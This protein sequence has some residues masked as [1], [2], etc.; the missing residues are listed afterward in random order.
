MYFSHMKPNLKKIF[1]IF[2]TIFSLSSCATTSVNTKVTSFYDNQILD[3]T[4]SFTIIPYE[5]QYN[6]IEYKTYGNMIVSKLEQFGLISVN[7]RFEANFGVM[8]RYDIG[9]GEMKTDW[10]PIINEYTN[11]DNP[12]IKD[13]ITE[14]YTPRQYV[15]YTKT[16]VVDI[17][18]LK[19]SERGGRSQI[20][21]GTV[22]QT[23]IQ[24][25][26]SSV[27]KCLIN[28]LF[29]KFPGQNGV[30]REVLANC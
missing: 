7:S 20:Y 10:Q 23:G 14:G 27:G 21:H 30:R 17:I 29:H 25:S 19:H 18:D 11:P 13:K 12:E 4:K 22:T 28:A 24:D 8:F 9:E 16:L 6:D 15:D 1:V 2:F 5:N 3:K 26:F